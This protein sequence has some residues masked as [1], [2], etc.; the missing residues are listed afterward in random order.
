MFQE[1]RIKALVERAKS[2][3]KPMVLLNEEID[4]VASELKVVF[5]EDF[6]EINKKFRFDNLHFDF[7]CFY[8][9]T[10]NQ[11]VEETRK[12]RQTIHIPHRYVVLGDM[13]DAGAIFIETQDSSKKSSPVIYCDQMD[14]DNL[15]EEKPLQF[16]PLLWPSFTDFFEYLVEQE[17]ESIK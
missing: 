11:V 13:G 4:T 8:L 16:N 14:V 9:K 15:I 5:S 1:N 10:C 2:I 17:E 12:F 7:F 3:K 6:Y